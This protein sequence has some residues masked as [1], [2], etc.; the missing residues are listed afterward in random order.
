MS[1][2]LISNTLLAAGMIL[3][4][5]GIWEWMQS[6]TGQTAAA[7]D[8]AAAETVPSATVR[9]VRLGDTVARLTIPRLKA[10]LYV[11]EGDDDAELRRAPGHLPGSALPGMPGNSVIAGHRDTHFRVLKDIRP[12]DDIFLETTAGKYRYQ[13]NSTHVVSPSNTSSLAP[14]SNAVLHLITCYPF[15]WVGSAPKR[16]VVEATLATR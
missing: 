3:A 6:L 12:G 5:F 15:Y 13:V 9:R 8:F 10:D 11:V 1:R 4:A 16:F 7:R 14:T 2:R